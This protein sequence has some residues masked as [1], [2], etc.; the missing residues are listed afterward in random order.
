MSSNR[1][2]LRLRSDF[3]LGGEEAEDDGLLES[4]FYESG[5]YHAVANT[6]DSRAF[7]I[8]RTGSGKSALLHHLATELPD[9]VIRIDPENLSL[10]YITNL[11]VVRNLA[12]LEINFDPFF[13]ALWKHVLLVEIIRHRYKITTSDVGNNFIAGL[14]ERIRKDASKK[15]ALDYFND[16]EG[17]FW[18]ETDQRI[19]DIITKF[20]ERIDSEAQA[21]LGVAHLAN[22]KGGIGS[23]IASSTEVRAE[24]IARFQL[25]VNE[26]QLPRLNK[27]IDVLGDDI[28]ESPQNFTYVIIDDLDR[29]W[30]DETV[31][32]DLIRCLFRAV[33]DLRRVRNLKII[34]ALR[35]NIFEELDFGSRKG[36]QEEKYRSGTLTVRW[37]RNELTELLNN[38]ALAAAEQG[39]LQLSSI[40]DL[41]PHANNTRGNALDHILDRTLMRPRDAIAYLNECFVMASGKPRLTWDI[42]HAAEKPYSNKRLLALR[43]EWKP[44][45]PGIDKVFDVFRQVEVPMTRKELTQRLDD[46]ILLP[47][48]PSFAGTEW[49]TKLSER[50]FDSVTREWAEEYMP[51]FRLLFDFGFIGC[52]AAGSTSEIYVYDRPEFAESISNLDGAVEFYIHPAFRLAVDARVFAKGEFM[53]LSGE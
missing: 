36:G 19:K 33:R 12:S 30:V 34:V 2:K 16:Y 14:I 24:Q 26:T 42:I 43:D 5:F 4:G 13:I 6:G 47:A 25:I 28:L 20:E 23:V 53:G 38:R 50:V 35:T 18:C 29:D 17:K 48:Q 40:D 49:M 21:S 46:A 8:G 22:L 11:S 10:P 3:N 51:L 41:V 9:H 44:T 37:N 7:I 1:P 27:M 52:R 32:N 45:Y 31:S 39:S 15:L